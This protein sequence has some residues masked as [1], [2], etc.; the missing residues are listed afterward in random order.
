MK[1]SWPIW[2]TEPGEGQQP[3]DVVTQERTE[4]LPNGQKVQVVETEATTEIILK[5]PETKP[6]QDGRFKAIVAFPDTRAGFAC[7][8]VQRGR[9]SL[10]AVVLPRRSWGARVSFGVIHGASAGVVATWD[11]EE[12]RV[13][14]R[15]VVGLTIQF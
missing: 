5:L 13:R 9:W 7:E 1:R 11:F 8:V 3:L 15:A 4:E 14:G 2:A 6:P 10:D 12:R